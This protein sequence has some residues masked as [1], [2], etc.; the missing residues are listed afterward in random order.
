ML[1]KSDF[2][3]LGINKKLTDF[4]EKQSELKIKEKVKDAAINEWAFKLDM[5]SND[6]IR[7]KNT[8]ENFDYA[9]LL[10]QGLMKLG[11]D[12]Q[13]AKVESVPDRT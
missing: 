2:P 11:I 9:M 7:T 10:V 4:L 12:T 8:D 5:V 3:F 13:E 6:Q 1:G